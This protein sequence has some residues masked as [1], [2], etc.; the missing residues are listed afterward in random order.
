VLGVFC[1]VIGGLLLIVNRVA[2]CVLLGLGVIVLVL[3]P[4]AAAVK[5][6]ERQFHP[7]HKVEGRTFVTDLWRSTPMKRTHRRQDQPRSRN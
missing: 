2:G 7:D 6:S 5:G 1:L 3:I 4:A